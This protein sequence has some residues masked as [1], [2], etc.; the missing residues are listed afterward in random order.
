MIIRKSESTIASRKSKPDAPLEIALDINSKKLESFEKATA[1]MS[2][3]RNLY[4]KAGLTRQVIS[5]LSHG[6]KIALMLE[7][8][9]EA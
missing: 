8:A 4:L 3:I 5:E 2:T 9:E 7:I 1:A 6:E